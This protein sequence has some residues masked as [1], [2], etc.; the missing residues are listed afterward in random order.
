MFL[1]VPAP[2]H[3]A[4]FAETFQDFPPRQEAAGFSIEQVLEK[5]SESQGKSSAVRHVGGLVFGRA[6]WRRTAGQIVDASRCV[7]IKFS[8]CLARRSFVSDSSM[9]LFA[10]ARGLTDGY[11]T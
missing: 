4:S 11:A 6:W 2:Q 3:V 10:F 5:L 1:F 8:A 9:A 7:R